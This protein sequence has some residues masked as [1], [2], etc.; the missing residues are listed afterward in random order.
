MS[1]KR[2]KR[3]WW[4]K[5]WRWRSRPCFFGHE[6]LCCPVTILGWIRD[7]IL[8][9]NLMLLFLRALFIRKRRKKEK[10]I[11]MEKNNK[12]VRKIV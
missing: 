3:C 9:I 8:P 5:G 12:N 6:F 2:W 11:I 1:W 4:W 7:L 10:I